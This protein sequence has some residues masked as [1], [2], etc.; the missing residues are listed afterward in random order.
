MISPHI[1]RT[2]SPVK[3][4][5][6]IAAMSLNRVIGA[7]SRIPWHLPEDFKWFKEMTTGQVIVMGRKTFESIGCV[8]EPPGPEAFSV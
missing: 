1:L 3:P 4:F 6:A 8:V 7:G 5:K 2:D